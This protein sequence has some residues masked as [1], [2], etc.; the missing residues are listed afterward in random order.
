MTNSAAAGVGGRGVSE[1]TMLA[2]MCHVSR[3]MFE[4]CSQIRTAAK[5]EAVEGIRLHLGPEDLEGVPVK[6]PVAEGNSP[7]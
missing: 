3:S 7:E 1:G 2:L 6:V 5:I 4:Q